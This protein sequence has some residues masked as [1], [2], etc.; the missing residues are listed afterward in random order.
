M[1]I[2]GFYTPKYLWAISYK[3]RPDMVNLGCQILLNLRYTVE[4]QVLWILTQAVLKNIEPSIFYEPFTKSPKNDQF[5][6][7]GF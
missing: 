6:Q 7:R 5:N 4:Q 2:I 1:F 3:P